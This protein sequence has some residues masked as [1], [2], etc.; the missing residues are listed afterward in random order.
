MMTFKDFC[1]KLDAIINA[2]R[3]Q[4]N[5]PEVISARNELEATISRRQHYIDSQLARANLI[6][7]KIGE[8][9]DQIRKLQEHHDQMVDEEEKQIAVFDEAETRLLNIIETP[10]KEIDSLAENLVARMF[11]V[12]TEAFLTK[13]VY[14]VDG[15][16]FNVGGVVSLNVEWAKE[17][18]DFDKSETEQALRK[19]VHKMV[20]ENPDEFGRGKLEFGGINQAAKGFDA[21]AKLMRE[22]GLDPAKPGTDKTVGK[23]TYP[24]GTEQ[25]LFGEP[26]PMTLEEVFKGSPTEFLPDSILTIVNNTLPMNQAHLADSASNFARVL[27]DQAD[28]DENSDSPV[29]F[30]PDKD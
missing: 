25:I 2:G 11:E 23:I 19:A 16:P 1:E 5:S 27:E 10:Q 12:F 18:Y 30:S 13:P 14:Y 28:T 15:K 9:A 20:D 22:S 8:K 26:I 29:D 4:H 24:D 7:S 21:L 6:R 3:D 17:Q